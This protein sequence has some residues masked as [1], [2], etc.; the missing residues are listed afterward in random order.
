MKNKAFFKI[1]ITIV[2][3]SLYMSCFGKNYPPSDINNVCEI[4]REY[5]S[6]YKD[7]YKSYQK[8]GIPIP[9]MMAILHQESKFEAKIKPP[10]TRCLFIFP[11]PRPSSAY[12]Y[13]QALDSTWES[14]LKDTRNFGADR[15]DFGDATDFVGWYCNLSSIKCGISKNNA[16]SL[17]LAYHEGQGGYNRK[18]YLNKSWLI[19]VAKKVQGRANTY[20]SQLSSCEKEFKKSKSCLWPF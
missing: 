13:A 4:F 19:Q 6:W 20:S 12:G 2:A 17:Y 18:T 3:M 14:Y 9:V 5:K 16:Y 1:L 7:A 15:D 10:R 8:W 11:G